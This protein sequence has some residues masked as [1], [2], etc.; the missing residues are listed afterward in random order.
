M[1]E[2][3]RKKKKILGR[4][5]TVRGGL[6]L[7]FGLIFA[8]MLSWSLEQFSIEWFIIRMGWGALFPLWYIEMNLVWGI[9]WEMPNISLIQM[10][11]GVLLLILPLF[12]WIMWLVQWYKKEQPIKN[13]EKWEHS[14]SQKYLTQFS[15]WGFL[16]GYRYLLW[17]K[18]WGYFFA[19]FFGYIILG[20]V[21]N[22]LLG[23]QGSAG[24]GAII[25]WVIVNIII[26]IFGK[27]RAWEGR[28]ESPEVFERNYR[29]ANKVCV[30]V[31]C[32]AIGLGILG[33][34]IPFLMLSRMM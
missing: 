29:K 10:C 16:V 18:K 17:A 20:G 3:K 30:I 22:F 8:I 1:T 23:G 24:I 5:F 9:L 7:I 28:K 32:V 26:G 33:A 2:K 31:F 6:S 14:L 21:L 13:K 11:V 19:F 25:I 34:L 12:L 4:V 15:R 27:K